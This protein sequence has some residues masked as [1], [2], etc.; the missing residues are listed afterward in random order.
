MSACERRDLRLRRVRVP[1]LRLDI[2]GCALA[3]LLVLLPGVA[4]AAPQSV[5]DFLALKP[6]WD[7]LVGSRFQLEGRVSTGAANSLKLTNLPLFFESSNELPDLS[8][9][10][11]APPLVVEVTATLSRDKNGQLFFILSTIKL[12]DDDETRLTRTM[13]VLPRDD[14]DKWYELA[15][16]AQRR[17]A[18]YE[19]S[20]LAEAAR[21]LIDKGLQR[22][23][24]LSKKRDLKS[25][26]RLSERLV[27]SDCRHHAS[28]NCSIVG[29]TMNGAATAAR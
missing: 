6:K 27:S 17:A 16:D 29:T 2:A 12:I 8:R 18:F 26:R 15:Q 13:R 3:L 24:A 1:V 23:E 7:Q 9:K 19:D 10:A 5:V 20:K 4:A 11:S 14:P 28:R 21:D 22:E 25:Y